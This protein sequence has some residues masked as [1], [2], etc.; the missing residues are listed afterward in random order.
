MTEVPDWVHVWAEALAAAT[1]ALEFVREP[2]T[3]PVFAAYMTKRA[4]EDWEPP[5]SELDAAIE[6]LRSI[7]AYFGII[8]LPAEALATLKAQGFK[9]ETRPRG[10]T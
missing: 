10:E 8:V 6:G 3:Y 7:G 1:C 5:R 9:P 2:E 4:Q